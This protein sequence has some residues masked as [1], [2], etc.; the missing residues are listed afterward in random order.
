M[1]AER[2]SARERRTAIWPW[3]VMPAIVL[4][5]FCALARVHHRPGS[6]WTGA[7]LHPAASDDSTPAGQ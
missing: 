7:W 6:S 5:V 3:L 2:R 4:A 1:A